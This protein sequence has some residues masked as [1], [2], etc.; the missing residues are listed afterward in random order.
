MSTHKHIELLCPA[1]NVDIGIAAVNHGA[2]AVYI[3]YQNFGAREAAGNPLQDIERL[4]R[5][6]H[7][8]HSRVYITL[9][10]ILYDNELEEV[11]R[12]I[13]L[14][15][16]MG[17]DALIIQDMGI[18]EMDLPPIAIHAST[19]TN[20]VTD[21]KVRFL[22]DIGVQR[23]ILARELSIKE[24]SRI[25]AATHVELEAFIHGALCVSYSGQCYMSHALTGRSANRGECAQ[26][27]RSRY[28][29]IDS[30]G[31]IIVKDKHLISLKDFNQSQSISALIEAGVSSLK[32]EGRLKDMG[33]VKNI[34]AHY[35]QILDKILEEDSNL[36]K[37]S[38]GKCVYSFSPEPNR[39]FN[40]GYTSYFAKGRSVNMASLNTPKSLGIL[41]GQVASCTKEFI[42][43]KSIVEINN[44]DG[45]CFF[46][47][48]NTLVGF[49]VNR[50]EEN[51][52]FPNETIAIPLGTSI[53]RNYDHNFV[54]ILKKD[55]TSTRRIEATIKIE[56]F[57]HA[58]KV[59]LC[60]EDA[61]T[62]LIEI[63]HDGTPANSRERMI[64]IIRKQLSKA[65][66]TAYSI[67]DVDVVA[68]G[69]DI[70]FLSVGQINELRR[71]LIEQHNLRRVE[72]HPFTRKKIE[73]IITPY[74][75]KRLSFKANISNKLAKQFYKTHGV[76]HFESA[77]ELA[78]QPY[79]EE[80]MTTRY[81][82]LSELKLC[83]GL[84]GPGRER[85]FL[86]DNRHKYPLHFNCS[87]CE[88]TIQFPK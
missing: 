68:G 22:Q 27:C 1:K 52:I 67:K 3:G 14:F 29:L 35:R 46:D 84:K 5:Y 49:K 2:D 79:G 75:E 64:D 8:Y 73:P 82:I 83:D 28:N 42:S 85:Y 59:S 54:H 76:E 86:Q 19:Q 58:L 37:A 78:S 32:I 56:F 74:P 65:G 11:Q 69:V 57:F 30:N 66:N 13:H 34:T 26:P 47:K 40:R 43:I 31:K 16:L 51:R 15:Y 39:T 60:D 55:N 62:T 53:Y 44:N 88:M 80:I 17:A 12:L 20:N 6:A 45:L 81:C 36:S 18:L 70:P 77:F 87:K 48:D 71:K 9:N 10:T 21:K 33:Y 72:S 25:R 50:V 61:V 24:I 38:S 4:I 7:L 63:P 23:V 41:I